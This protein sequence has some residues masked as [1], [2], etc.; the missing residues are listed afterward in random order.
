MSLEN[1]LEAE[2]QANSAAAYF[3]PEAPDTSEQE[4]SASLERDP[5]AAQFVVDELDSSGAAK[6]VQ[7]AEESPSSEQRATSSEQ[8][9]TDSSALTARSSPLADPDWR[10][11]V[12]AK[13]S[14]YK[15]RSRHKPRYP[16]LQL[17]F[18]S[19]ASISNR[20]ETV[21]RPS[22]SFSQAVAAEI[23]A[24]QPNATPEP[25]PRISLE[26]TARVLEFPRPSPPAF[27]PDELAESIVDRPRIVEAPEVLPPP[28]AMGGILIEPTRQP[29][30]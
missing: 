23:V 14:S 6:P 29:E 7:I 12:S 13:V 11:Q 28:P 22:L 5:E 18:G 19:S 30:P 3:D 10:D 9:N 8:T 20:S 26:A 25:E 4:F 21:D 15:S 16:S 17:P 2:A 1:P 27:D 24:L